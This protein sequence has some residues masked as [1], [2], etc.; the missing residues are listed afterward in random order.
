VA[1]AAQALALTALRCG[2]GR[3]TP[4]GVQVAFVAPI[5]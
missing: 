1:L 2:A 3:P 5:L 4:E